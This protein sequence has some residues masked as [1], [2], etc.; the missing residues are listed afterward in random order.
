[1]EL[2]SLVSEK[3]PGH[4][5]IPSTAGS[6]QD[7]ALNSTPL[8]QETVHWDQG[9]HSCHSVTAPATT[10]DGWHDI[11]L[12]GRRKN[13][14][15]KYGSPRQSAI[16]QSADSVEFPGH[17]PLPP[18]AG[19]LHARALSLVPWPQVVEHG[20]HPPHSCHSLSTAGNDMVN[21]ILKE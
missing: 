7:R 14:I 6:L 4:L 9:L 17:V 13:K 19:S 8:P 16:R 18:K 11:E 5:P 3:F 12:Q 20:D 15:A 21:A 10:I 2:H 1:M